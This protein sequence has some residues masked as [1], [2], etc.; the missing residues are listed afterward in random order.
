L[1]EALSTGIPVVAT[2]VGGT[3]EIVTDSVHGL[4]IPPRD[5][6]AMAD[7]IDRILADRH[8]AGQLSAAGKKMVAERFTPAI[9]AELLIRIFRDVLQKRNPQRERER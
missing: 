1:L 3:P 4:L 7:A 6:H 9:R 8:L 5:P 2:K